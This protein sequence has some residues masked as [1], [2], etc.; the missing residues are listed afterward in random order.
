MST[1]V[2]PTCIKFVSIF[3]QCNE[4]DYSS[5]LSDSQDITD[6]KDEKEKNDFDLNLK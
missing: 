4:E 2:C 3:N 1:L 6:L 5:F